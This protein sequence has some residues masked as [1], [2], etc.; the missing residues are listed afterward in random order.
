MSLV[1]V[2]ILSLLFIVLSPGFM[3]DFTENKYFKNPFESSF[4]WMIFI[5]IGAFAI[6]SYLYLWITGKFA[7]KSGFKNMSK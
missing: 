6:L 7:E 2:L 5:N 3:F 1:D 4:K